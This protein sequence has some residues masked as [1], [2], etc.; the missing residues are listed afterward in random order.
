MTVATLGFSLTRCGVVMSPT[1]D[2][3]EAEGVL[4][5]ASGRTPDGTLHLLTWSRAGLQG[6]YSRHD[7]IQRALGHCG[8][9]MWQTSAAI[10]LASVTSAA[11]LRP[12]RP[13]GPN[14]LLV[15]VLMVM[16]VPPFSM[17]SRHGGHAC[18][19]YLRLSLEVNLLRPPS[20][21]PHSLVEI[22]G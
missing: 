21:L 1:D 18:C 19:S 16:G 4:N 5:P 11:A 9:A 3:N 20:G 7:S 12:E 22:L 14:T 8:P 15:M 10:A 6:G 13:A 2:P 17:V